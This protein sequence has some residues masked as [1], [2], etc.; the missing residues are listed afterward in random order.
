[1]NS[2]PAPER[3]LQIY[4]AKQQL[5]FKHFTPIQR[6]EWLAA[7]NELYWAGI[8]MRATKSGRQHKKDL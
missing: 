5:Q 1:M 4:S 3:G 2:F 8:K 6:L 7:I